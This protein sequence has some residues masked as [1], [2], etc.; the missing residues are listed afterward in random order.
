[1][2][3]YLLRR[4]KFACPSAPCGVN[5]NSGAPHLKRV[6]RKSLDRSDNVEQNCKWED[7]ASTSDPGLA[8]TDKDEVA[9]HS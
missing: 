3:V 5:T 9:R 6:M 2:T 1:M 4:A 8:K 7:K